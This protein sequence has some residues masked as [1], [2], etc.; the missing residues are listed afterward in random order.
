MTIKHTH[1]INFRVYYEDTDSGGVVYYA[2]YLKFAERARTEM[3]REKGV[4]QS[5]LAADSGILFVVRKVGHELLAPARL[6]DMLLVTT[7]IKNISGASIHMLQEI[8]CEGKKIAEVDVLVVCIN[9]KFKTTRIPD[10]IRKL[11]S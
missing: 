10:D 11:L 4:R 8:E 9:Q 2:N 1:T 5:T 7:H 3:L 6:D